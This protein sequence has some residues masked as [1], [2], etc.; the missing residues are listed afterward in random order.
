MGIAQILGLSL[1]SL[2]ARNQDVAQNPRITQTRRGNKAHRGN[3][4][5]REQ[6]YLRGC[7][8]PLKILL[9]QGTV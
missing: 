3:S 4:Y 7:S 2:G 1:I 5:S 6:Y 8:N 9:T